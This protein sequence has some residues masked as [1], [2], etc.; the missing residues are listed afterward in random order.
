MGF[1]SQFN[2]QPQQQGSQLSNVMQQAQNLAAQ[3]GGAQAVIDQLTSN[4]ARSATSSL[5]S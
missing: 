2:Q 1:L 5:V 4:G 3:N